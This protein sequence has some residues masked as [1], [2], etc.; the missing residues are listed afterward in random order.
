LSFRNEY[1]SGV[2]RASANFAGNAMKA[3]E[4]EKFRKAVTDLGA[5]AE[6]R[7]YQTNWADT[8]PQMN[9]DKRGCFVRRSG[10]T[11]RTAGVSSRPFATGQAKDIGIQ[12]VS[13]SICC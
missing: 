9:T 4:I 8:W 7:N 11:K 2:A 6:G 3:W 13:L 5:E 12:F 10:I 1:G